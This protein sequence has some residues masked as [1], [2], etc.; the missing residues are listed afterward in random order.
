MPLKKMHQ[1]LLAFPATQA[2]LFDTTREAKDLSVH[3]RNVAGDH[4]I[5]NGFVDGYNKWIFH[6]ERLSSRNTPLS[7]NHDDIDGTTS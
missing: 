5:V 4:L 3:Y 7:S 2:P 1:S 6:G